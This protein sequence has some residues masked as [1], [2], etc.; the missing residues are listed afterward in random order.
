[1]V[2]RRTIEK[3]FVSPPRLIW[4]TVNTKTLHT[5]LTFPDQHSV[6]L[7]AVPG[8]PKSTLVQRLHLILTIL[9]DKYCTV[10][11]FPTEQ[12]I[13]NLSRTYG[14]DQEQ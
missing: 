13:P 6:K 2:A 3:N 5:F 9:R 14:K 12:L 11:T 7:T 10:P 8:S 4:N 1:M